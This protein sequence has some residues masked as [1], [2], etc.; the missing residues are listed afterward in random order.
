MS[1]DIAARKKFLR[2]EIKSRLSKISPAEKL[3]LSRAVIQK[4][5]VTETY[6]DAKIIMAYLSMP[7]EI[8]LQ[9]FFTAAFADEKILTVP[10]IS[11]GEMSAVE[12]PNM[13]ALEIGAYGILTVK[14]DVRKFIDAA[15][16]DCIITPGLAFDMHGHRLGRGGGFYD[17]F[18]SRAVNAKKIALAYD[19]QIVNSVPV[20]T[21]DIP[22]DVVLT[23][24]KS[25]L[26][27]ENLLIST[28]QV[29]INQC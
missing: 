9:E 14:S 12:L 21:F 16:I 11:A 5:L 24:T 13:N 7:D 6:K 23:P 20:E 2:R 25:E 29:V 17:K 1:E 22:V 28:K 27:F 10:F 18:L 15:E 8:Q 19:C 4:F 26:K 3:D